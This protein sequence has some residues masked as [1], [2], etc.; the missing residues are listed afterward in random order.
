[1]SAT[2]PSPRIVAPARL[3]TPASDGPSPFTTTSCLPSS[4]SATRH[5]ALP[6][7]STSTSTPSMGATGAQLRPK[8]LGEWTIGTT[9]PRSFTIWP[10]RGR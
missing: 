2:R 3:A 1:M 10:R 6:P 4:S 9:A 5:T 8:P 7:S